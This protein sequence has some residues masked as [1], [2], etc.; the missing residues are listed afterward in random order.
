MHD[1]QSPPRDPTPGPGERAATLLIGLILLMFA[2][3]WLQ[4]AAADMRR[5]V[6]A[7]DAISLSAP[8]SVSVGIAGELHPLSTGPAYLPSAGA[9]AAI[10][11]A[12]PPCPGPVLSACP[13]HIHTLGPC[14]WECRP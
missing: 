2:C 5:G 6:P 12:P 3:A 11:T 9:P 7:L 4:S 1:I 13:G 10:A 14:Q 8:A